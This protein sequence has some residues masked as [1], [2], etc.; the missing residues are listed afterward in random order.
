M[1]IDAAQW[2]RVLV[3]GFVMLC[4]YILFLSELGCDATCQ[5]GVFGRN[6][7]RTRRQELEREQP[8]AGI[9]L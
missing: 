9:R 5:I 4:S 6:A 3:L 1:H 2:V 8:I 7:K